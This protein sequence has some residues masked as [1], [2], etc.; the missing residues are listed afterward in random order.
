MGRGSWQGHFQNHA[1][2]L[3]WWWICL[4]LPPF[5]IYISKPKRGGIFHQQQINQW[6]DRKVDYVEDTISS[7]WP[8][9]NGSV[10]SHDGKYAEHSIYFLLSFSFSISSRDTNCTKRR[11]TEN[12]YY[13]RHICR[14]DLKN[15][16][17]GIWLLLPKALWW[18]LCSTKHSM[19]SLQKLDRH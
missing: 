13:V 1:R 4:S 19:S 5:A 11:S 16:G 9:G 12:K 17:Y 2:N 10:Y 15:E 7:S 6:M 18:G 3:P 14:S 8:G